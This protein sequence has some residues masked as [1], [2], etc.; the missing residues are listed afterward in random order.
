MLCARG[1]AA[2]AAYDMSECLIECNFRLKSVA[3]ARVFA[4]DRAQKFTSDGEG[5]K[6]NAL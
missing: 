1:A 2:A 6:E 5:M 3:G 4:N